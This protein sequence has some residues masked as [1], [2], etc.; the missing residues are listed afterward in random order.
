MIPITG[1]LHLSY[2]IQQVNNIAGLKREGEKERM[3]ERG[4]G[5]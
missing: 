3:R 2:F 4:R 1:K 5:S